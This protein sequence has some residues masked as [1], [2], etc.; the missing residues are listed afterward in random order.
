MGVFFESVVN[1]EYWNMFYKAET[2][3]ILTKTGQI[4]LH[5]IFLD[6]QFRINT[7][8]LTNFINY[9]FYHGQM[10]DAVKTVTPLPNVL[11]FKELFNKKLGIPHNF[12]VVVVKESK[13]FI[14]SG[15]NSMYNPAT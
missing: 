14:E 1:P 5:G 9:I 7:P 13:S 15:G 11:F 6:E 2:T 4:T 10:V 12:A 3:P 8:M